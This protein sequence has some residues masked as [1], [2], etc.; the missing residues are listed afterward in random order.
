MM[1][2]LLILLAVIAVAAI[3][4]ASV[5][6]SDGKPVVPEG[7]GIITLDAGE[8]EAFPLPDYA[9]KH[10]TD[11]YKSYF[12]EVEPGIKVHVLEVGSGFPVFLQHGNPT[13][14]FLYR[15]V[16]A[17]LPTDRLRLIM[18]TLVG[19]GFSSKIP[20]SRHTLENHMRWIN[21]VLEQLK[22]KELVYVGQ[23]W[24]GPIGMGALTLS[25]NLLKG[26]VL[27]NTGIKAPTEKINVSRAHA[28][29]KT[30]IVGELMLEVFT[31]IFEQLH[32]IQGD[33]G[34]IPA[35]VVE[36]YG[37]PVLESGN[38]KAPLA[39]MRMVTDGPDH[40]STAAMKAIEQY[41]QGLDIPAE[42]VW[43]MKD[44]ILGHL[45]PTMKLNFPKAPVTETKGGHFLQEEVPDQIAAAVL[46]IVNQV[47]N[48]ETY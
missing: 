10:V 25:P 12:V 9:A 15:K 23:D 42:I 36:L 44:P 26:A 31:S 29:V 22:L 21:S 45:L 47:Q 28:I 2:I 46:R 43:G 39:M 20:A 1:K 8:F 35:D 7:K 6:T 37:R 30:P 24:G 19:L 40:P 11:D 38:A 3:L 34:S 32:R 13:S 48:S 33:S 14:G 16:A 18:P 27:L 17:E 41:V 5:I 4:F